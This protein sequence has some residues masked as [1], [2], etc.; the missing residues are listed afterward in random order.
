MFREY[1]QFQNVLVK[2][3]LY[4]KLIRLVHIHI[5]KNIK[6]SITEKEKIN[7]MSKN[8]SE[9]Y[10]KTSYSLFGVNI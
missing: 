5:V 7:M 6:N 2:Y 3:I 10:I 8:V 9:C 4:S 1:K